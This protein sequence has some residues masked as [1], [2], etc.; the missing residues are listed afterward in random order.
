MQYKVSYNGAVGCKKYIKD[1]DGELHRFVVTEAE[2][3][4]DVLH[5]GPAA[6]QHTAPGHQTAVGPHLYPQPLCAAT[7]RLSGHHPSPPG[8]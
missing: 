1:N 6:W 2:R 5:S 4:A 3:E 8:T 7:A